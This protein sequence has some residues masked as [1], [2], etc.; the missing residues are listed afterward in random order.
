MSVI[1]PKVHKNGVRPSP[2]PPPLYPARLVPAR[3]LPAGEPACPCWECQ[4]RLA[5][6][7]VVLLRCF[8]AGYTQRKTAAY[9]NITYQTLKN[10]VTALLVKLGSVNSTQAVAVAVKRGLI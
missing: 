4:G 8:A 10:R 9:M 5:H 2:E 7:D 1:K 3:A 6:Q